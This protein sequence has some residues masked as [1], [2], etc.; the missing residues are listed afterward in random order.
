MAFWSGSKHTSVCVL[1]L[2]LFVRSLFSIVHSFTRLL[3][4]GVVL[5]NRKVLKKLVIFKN[6]YTQNL[7]TFLY[8][9]IFK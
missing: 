9:I 2:R 3:L 6:S 1:E 8:L 5:I 7:V 4:D